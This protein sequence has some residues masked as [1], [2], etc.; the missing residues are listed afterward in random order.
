MLT[1]YVPTTINN[2]QIREACLHC[3][4]TYDKHIE[5]DRIYR[6]FAHNEEDLKFLISRLQLKPLY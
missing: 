3:K 5:I 2:Q 1:A 6:F 4:A